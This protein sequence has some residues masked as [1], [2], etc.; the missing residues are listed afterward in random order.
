MA[1]ALCLGGMSQAMA[2]TVNG[3]GTLTVNSTVTAG[4]C[5]F[6][7][8]PTVDLV[9]S[10]SAFPKAVGGLAG[11]LEEVKIETQNCPQWSNDQAKAKLEVT[12]APAGTNYFQL[13][14]TAS[15][16]PIIA[17]HAV[18][19]TING[20]QVKS[21]TAIDLSDAKY[22]AAVGDDNAIMLKAGLVNLG[23]GVVAAAQSKADLTF[24]LTYN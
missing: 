16:T 2:D 17:D 21:G 12:G 15:G 14:S 8:I 6:K 11:G 20:E 13:K 5:T 18:S 3:A 23:T 7:A 22:K 10:T 1:A 19:L 9:A 4:T 24:K